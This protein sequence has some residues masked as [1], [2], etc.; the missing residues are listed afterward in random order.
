MD[1]GLMAGP[2]LD[3][4]ASLWAWA[5]T[6]LTFGWLVIRLIMIISRLIGRAIRLAARAA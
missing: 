2:A 3:T 6:N 1:G 4:L 5:M